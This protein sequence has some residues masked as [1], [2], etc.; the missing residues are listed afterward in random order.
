MG[1]IV[2]NLDVVHGDKNGWR[3]N[4]QT[5]WLCVF[6]IPWLVVKKEPFTIGHKEAKRLVECLHR[7]RDELFVF[8][9]KD[10]VPFDNNHAECTIRGAVVTRKNSYSKRNVDGAKT[11][12][13]LMNVFPTL[14]QQNTN[15][16]KT[17][18]RALHQFL[19]TKKL[20]TP[21]SLPENSRY[22]AE[23][24]QRINLFL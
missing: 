20:P 14:K 16:T 12:A 10:D 24:L 22:S 11:Q 23:S 7:H 17:I 6:T 3:I 15:V 9:T 8:I 13:I 19:T 4:G 18:E 2:K 5:H 1:G 21:A